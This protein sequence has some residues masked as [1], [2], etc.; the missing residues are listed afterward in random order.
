VAVDVAKVNRV[1]AGTF[2]GIYWSQDGG[3]TWKPLDQRLPHRR[4][5]IPAFV[6]DRIV[7]GTGGSGAYWMPVTPQAAR[8]LRAK[9]V[10]VAALPNAS[11][12]TVS[13]INGDMSRGISTPD[14]WKI[15]W[16]GSGKLR[17]ARD[18]K[19]FKVLQR[20]C[21]SK[22]KAARLT[23]MPD[24]TTWPRRSRLPSVVRSNLPEH[25]KKLLS[26][27]RLLTPHSN[28]SRLSTW[29]MR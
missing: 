24:K 28:R 25:C 22:A 12:Q 14:D 9:A 7:V 16:T 18:T 3:T 20:A 5:G 26:P 15:G 11:T 21:A 8:P 27:F 29:Q 1:V 6:G 23:A 10:K 17:L 19:D 4:Y 2:D 13:I